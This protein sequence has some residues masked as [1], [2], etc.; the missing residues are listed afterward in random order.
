MAKR[1]LSEIELLPNGVKSTPAK[2]VWETL[3][4]GLVNIQ[5][6]MRDRETQRIPDARSV[7]NGRRYVI[8]PKNVE[9][10]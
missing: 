3:S 4:N 6:A 10:I 7:E 2:T 1:T 8:T 5:Q 9:D